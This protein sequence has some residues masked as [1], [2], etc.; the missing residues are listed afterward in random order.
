MKRIKFYGV[1]I[2]MCAFMA[3]TAEAQIWKKIKDKTKSK[4]EERVSDK[5]S[6]KIA[7]AVIEKIDVQFKSPNNPYGNIVRSGKPENL[8]ESYSFDWKFK[9]KITNAG[10]E[11]E[12]LFDYYLTSTGNYVGYEMPQAEG[13]FM[14]MDAEL[15]STIS[16]VEEDGNSM[17]I[18]YSLPEDLT[19][20]EA[21][22]MESEDL[23][24]TELP[25]KIDYGIRISG[26]TN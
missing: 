10:M 25:S 26:K 23:K 4:V 15:K 8:P 3:S 22:E 24:I 12:L 13:M 20:T 5:I 6:E 2:M 16:Y 11:D 19:S 7:N 17:A 18:T 1:L 14:V 9:M 21:S